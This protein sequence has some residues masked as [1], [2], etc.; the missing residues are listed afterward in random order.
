L[1]ALLN[2][3]DPSV[4]EHGQWALELIRG[5]WPD[6][7]KRLVNFRLLDPN[8]LPP[9]TQPGEGVTEY[10]ADAETA[11]RAALADLRART[12]REWTA[13]DLTNLTQRDLDRSTSRADDSPEVGFALRA[14]RAANERAGVLTW[15]REMV[16]QD[17]QAE[18]IGEEPIQ[19]VGSP[20]LFLSYRWSQEVGASGTL[21]FFAGSL[22]NRGYDLVFDRDPRHLDKHLAAGV[23]L[24]LLYGC[25]HFV[26]LETDEL[27]DFLAE[28]TR[29]RNSPIDLELEL[30]RALAAED[31]L[32]WMPVRVDS[33]FPSD[34]LFPTRCFQVVATF[35]DGHQ[36][37]SQ[38]VERRH[39]RAMAARAR[40]AVDVVEVEI[41]VSRDQPL[42]S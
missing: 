4:A 24:L 7:W 6:L 20:R 10:P 28:S 38:P 17:R 30:A 41:H 18:A 34:E 21:D 35:A 36:E 14:P 3:P 5:S 40:E 26:L 27:A 13:N 37:K 23:M 11:V 22:F 15:D 39:L 2:D 1:L 25:T 12:N 19:V 9:L 16:A 8:G 42:R 32:K 31:R 29:T 33:P